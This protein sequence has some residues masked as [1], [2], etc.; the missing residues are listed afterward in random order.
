M[1]L[2]LA[3]STMLSSTTFSSNSRNVHRT[4]PSGGAEQANAISFASFSPSKIFRTAGMAR[5]LQ[6]RTASKPSSTTC[7]RP[8]NHRHVGPKDLDDPTV[9]PSFAGFADIGLQQDPRLGQRLRRVFSF[10]INSSRWWRSSAL[11][12]TTCFFTGTSL[13]CVTATPPWLA[14]KANQRMVNKSFQI[15]SNGL[16]LTLATSGLE[17]SSSLERSADERIRARLTIS[18]V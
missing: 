7:L 5:C 6:L 9:A 13:K 8:T 11:N 15:S 3:L 10:P 12:L 4:L 16:T 14:T 2:S 18:H 1:V 17:G